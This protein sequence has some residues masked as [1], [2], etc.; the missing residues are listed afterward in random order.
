LLGE[1]EAEVEREVELRVGVGGWVRAVAA[2]AAGVGVAV[3]ARLSPRT[4]LAD[5]AP[6]TTTRTAVR[7]KTLTLVARMGVLPAGSGRR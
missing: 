5:R 3:M 6:R 2:A 7:W 4:A 1:R